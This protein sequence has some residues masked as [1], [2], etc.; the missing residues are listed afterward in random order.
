FAAVESLDPPSGTPIILLTPHGRTFDHF[1]AER[2][3]RLA[4]FV[5]IAGHYE[6][7]DQRVAEHLA[8]EEISIGD[9]VLSAGEIAAMAVTD[10]VVR[11]LPGAISEGGAEVESFISGLL[12]YPQYTRPARF[13]EWEVPEVLLSGNHAQVELWRHEQAVA[14]TSLRRPDLLQRD[15]RPAEK[16]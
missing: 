11:L 16:L 9:F 13:R 14:L 8:T 6:G 10:A 15:E 4:A 3:S 1:T 12:E 7:V 5:L 2:L